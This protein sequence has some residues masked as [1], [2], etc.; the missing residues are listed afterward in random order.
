MWMYRT[1]A[2][3]HD[4]ADTLHVLVLAVDDDEMV[5]DSTL[6]YIQVGSTCA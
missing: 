5:Q 3:Y 2:L 4:S 6:M 1:S